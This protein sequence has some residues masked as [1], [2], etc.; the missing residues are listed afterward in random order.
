MMK[1]M[2]LQSSH[3]LLSTPLGEML[4][5]S[6]DKGLQGCWF[7]GQ[8]HFP[9]EFMNTG[10]SIQLASK[11]AIDHTHSSPS[12][13]LLVKAQHELDL[14]FNDQIDQF[15]IPLDLE[16][17]GTPFQQEVWTALRRIPLG[18]TMTYGQIAE[19]LKRPRAHRA[20]GSAIGKNPISI[21]VP[22]HR[23][24]GQDGTLTGYAGG[25]ERK[26]ALLN[27]ES[28]TPRA[29]QHKALEP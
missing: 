12:T 18:H 26:K 29:Q 25:I 9:D 28:S 17:R 21:F 8:K 7:L 11:A 3:A 6:S 13:L 1:K 5:L 16:T 4:A 22:C 14:Y 27:F 20:V 2:P 19:H 23:V 10:A 24:L 15:S